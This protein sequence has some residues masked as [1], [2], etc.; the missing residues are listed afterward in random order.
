[1]CSLVSML[2]LVANTHVLMSCTETKP[3][4][5]LVAFA[6]IDVSGQPLHQKVHY[7]Q[8]GQHVNVGCQYTCINEL[9]RN[10]TNLVLGCI[11]LH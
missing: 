6:C 3:T 11:C 8:S 5:Y 1:M 9:H 7:V 4:W 2:M 10:K